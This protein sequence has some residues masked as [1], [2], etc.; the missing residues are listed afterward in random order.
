MQ[1]ILVTGGTGFIGSH[2]VVSLADAGYHVVIIDDLSNSNMGVLDGIEKITGTRPAFFKIDL[3]DPDAVKHFFEENTGFD[4]VIHF[5][6]FK[7]VG[8]SVLNP[9]KYYKNNLFSL[10]NL[11]ENMRLNEIRN[12]VFSS[13]CTVY[14]QPDVL[15]VTE[16]SAIQKAE[17]PYGSTKIISEQIIEDAVKA[18]LLNAISLRYFNPIGAHPSA[19]IGELPIGTPNNL[20]PVVTQTA[21][22]KREKVIVYGDDY[23]TPDGSCIRDYIH[24]IDLAKAHVVALRRM[25]S[26]NQKSEY[27]IFN[28]GTGTGY[29]VLE[30]LHTFEKVAALKLNFEIGPRRPGDITKIYADTTYANKELGWKAEENLESMIHSAWE[31]EKKLSINHS[32]SA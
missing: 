12:L 15:P 27:E 10:V 29:S 14:G 4:G 6:A 30:V 28:V 24:V 32:L 25:I 20:I 18:G 11:L 8:E 7:A 22:G 19:L 31:W 9:L 2:T 23:D 13:S 1:K 26:Q 21:I 5:A 17:S 16:N 3:T